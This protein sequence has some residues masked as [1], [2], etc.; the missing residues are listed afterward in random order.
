MN[1]TLAS[2]VAAEG[3]KIRDRKRD[4]IK[5]PFHDDKEPSMGISVEEGWF[6]CFAASCEKKGDAVNWLLYRGL[7]KRD[8]LRR[9]KGEATF[10]EQK[11]KWAG[12]SGTRIQIRRDYDDPTIEKDMWWEK[13]PGAPPQTQ[14]VYP[15]RPKRGEEDLQPYSLVFCEGAK[16]AKAVRSAGF[17][18]C[19]YV[20]ATVIPTQETLT[21]VHVASPERTVWILWPDK[22]DGAI[23]ALNRFEGRIPS[24]VKVL[25]V[26]PPEHLSTGQDAADCSVEQIRKGIESAIPWTPIAADDKKEESGG[27]DGAGSSRELIGPQ[28]SLVVNDEGKP[29][30]NLPRNVWEAIHQLGYEVGWNE[31]HQNVNVWPRGKKSEATQITDSCWSRWITLAQHF[32]GVS[33]SRQMFIDAVV[34]W[35]QEN[36]FH[37]IKDY[38]DSCKW[39]DSETE[40]RMFIGNFVQAAFKVEDLASKVALYKW[41]CAAVRRIRQPGCEWK[42]VPVLIGP[43]NYRKSGVIGSLSPARRWFL[44]KLDFSLNQK[45]FF[46]VVNGSWLIEWSE[47]EGISA[48]K[49]G[50][51][52]ARISTEF[53]KYRRSYGRETEVFERQCV[54]IASSNERNFLNFSTGKARFWPITMT[55]AADPE[56]GAENRDRL[57]GSAALLESHEKL[58]MDLPR[59]EA[60]FDDRREAAYFVDPWEETL[61]QRIDLA[62]L[63]SAAILADVL[64]ESHDRRNSLRLTRTMQ[65]LGYERKRQG[66]R[67]DHGQRPWVWVRSG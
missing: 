15:R 63:S 19:A 44:D 17:A 12:P 57:W 46:D 58:W 37:P 5:C 23:K 67:D 14:L 27:A 64:K 31:F 50:S 20:N 28:G 24:G 49:G 65:R 32:Y 21:W 8:A 39:T 41:F 30:K 36:K 26:V 6:R 25:F 42:Y 22:D 34:T 1:E 66:E 38:L 54:F 33:T 11:I 4:K 62:G 60:E 59:I 40:A 9:V 45:D 18:V 61:V 7:S 43:E 53:D 55:A 13:S 56:Y 3:I 10:R 35:A 2:I 47:L 29:Y 16:T 52:K 48:F 51:I